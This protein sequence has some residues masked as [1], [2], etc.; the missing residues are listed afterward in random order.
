MVQGKIAKFSSTNI[1]P[2]DSG[3]LAN[4]SSAYNYALYQYFKMAV[5]S[6]ENVRSRIPLSGKEF[7]VANEACFRRSRPHP[8][9]P[10]SSVSPQSTR[11]SYTLEKRARMGRCANENGPAKAF[12]QLEIASYSTQSTIRLGLHCSDDITL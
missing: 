10:M 6:S 12:S 9:G 2:R 5:Y 7:R 8:I 4:H 11:G 1:K 3:L